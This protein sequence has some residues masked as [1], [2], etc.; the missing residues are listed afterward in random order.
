MYLPTHRQI[1]ILLAFSF[2]VAEIKSKVT[3]AR[4]KSASV[5]TTIPEAIVSLLKLKAGD[6][7]R[8]DVAASKDSLVVTITRVSHK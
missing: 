8:W 7:L 2:A 6:E 5:R 4:P 3:I 1:H